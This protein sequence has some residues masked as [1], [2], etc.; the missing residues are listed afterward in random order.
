MKSKSTCS[1]SLLNSR[2]HWLQVTTHARRSF[3]FLLVICPL[4]GFTRSLHTPLP[5]TK[6]FQYI[7]ELLDEQ[8]NRKKQIAS[9]LLIRYSAPPSNFTGQITKPKNTHLI[10][11]ADGSLGTFTP[12]RRKN[13][14]RLPAHFAIEVMSFSIG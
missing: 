2:T 14:F 8:D 12:N 4:I 1:T 9:P 13:E 10:S 11:V 7:S 3:S 6:L 5:R